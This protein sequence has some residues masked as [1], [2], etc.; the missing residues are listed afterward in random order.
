M[1]STPNID[2][3]YLIAGQAQA[4]VTLNDA[5][6]TIDALLGQGALD[7]D[8]TDPGTLTPSNGDVYIVP[9]SAVGAWSTH[10]GKV[11]IYYDGWTLIEPQEGWRLWVR[12]EDRPYL[13]NGTAWVQSPLPAPSYTVNDLPSGQLEGSVAYATDGRKA[14][15]SFGNGTGV[16]VFYDGSNWKAVDTGLTVND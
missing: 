10:D 7:K 8:V 15:E 14:G 5:L 4:E 6:N 1:S 11:A 2:M 13:Y 3:P 12:D 16:L 9:S